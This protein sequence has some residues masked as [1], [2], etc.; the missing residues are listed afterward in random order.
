MDAAAEIG[1]NSVR[2]ISTRFSLSVENEQADAGRDGRDCPVKLNNSQVRAG[3][4]EYSFSLFSAHHEHDWQ[5][6]PV[7]LCSIISDG[8]HTYDTY[9]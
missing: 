8:I 1:R 3:T 5:P 2:N 9:S 4:G 6:Y 7:D